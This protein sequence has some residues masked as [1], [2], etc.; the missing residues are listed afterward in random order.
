MF[1]IYKV[2]G[3]NNPLDWASSSK[4]S[5]LGH[6]L[7]HLGAEEKI[8]EMK[9]DLDWQYNWSDFDIIEIEVLP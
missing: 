5:T 6:Y 1:T 2:I 7:S 3:W 4:S 9:M 8:A